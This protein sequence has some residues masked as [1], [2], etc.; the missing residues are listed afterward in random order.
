NLAMLFARLGVDQDVVQIDNNHTFHNEL[1]EQVVHHGLEGRRAVGQSEE[2]HQRFE[3]SARSPKCGLPLI[4]LLDPDIV[5]TPPDVELG[6]VASV[7]EFIHQVRDERK[8]VPI[9]DRHAVELPVVLD[10]AERSV[11]LLNKEHRGSHG[12]LAGADP[13]SPEIFFQKLV[14]LFLLHWGQRIALGRG[15]FR[16]VH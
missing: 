16:S 12:R 1:P 13:T 4:T 7:P 10:Q 8:W 3:E 6:E 2:H 5:E 9:L 11:L 15:R 14:Q